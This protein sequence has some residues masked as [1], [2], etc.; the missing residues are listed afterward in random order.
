M[1][2]DEVLSSK[3]GGAGKKVTIKLEQNITTGIDLP[4]S[5]FSTRIHDSRDW[6]YVLSADELDSQGRYIELAYGINKIKDAWMV[7]E[8]KWGATI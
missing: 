1:H 4:N 2:V 5:A 7:T 8:L 6:T 3:S